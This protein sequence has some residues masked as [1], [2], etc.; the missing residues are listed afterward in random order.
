MRCLPGGVRA[1][2]G[3]NALLGPVPRGCISLAESVRLGLVWH[4]RGRT[5]VDS[6]AIAPPKFPLTV[7]RKLRS[8]PSSLLCVEP[9][10]TNTNQSLYLWRPLKCPP[11]A[12]PVKNPENPAND[13]GISRNDPEKS[14]NDL[15]KCGNDSGKQQA[16]WRAL[17]VTWQAK[18]DSRLL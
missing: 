4:G 1:T 15:E 2:A 14:G 10:Q 13:L 11:W 12:D 16:L 9:A 8:R 17:P 18:C 6:D 7:V 5:V 3:W